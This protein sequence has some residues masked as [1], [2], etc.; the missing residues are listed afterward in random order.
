MDCVCVVQPYRSTPQVCVVRPYRS[1]PQV[2]EQYSRTGLPPKCVCSTAVQVYPPSVCVVQSYRSTLQ[3][4]CCR[5]LMMSFLHENLG[6]DAVRTTYRIPGNTPQP[7]I[8]MAIMKAYRHRPQFQFQFQPSSFLAVAPQQFSS[9]HPPT[10]LG[11]S[12]FACRGRRYAL[13]E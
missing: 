2:C 7:P 11:S 10:H 6:G 4:S 12:L 3:G 5:K 8:S 13:Q 9:S 1:T